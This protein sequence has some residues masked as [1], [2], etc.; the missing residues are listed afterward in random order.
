MK[1]LL[2]IWL[3]GICVV[4]AIIL[5]GTGANYLVEFL[6]NSSASIMGGFVVIALLL[7]SLAV[8]LFVKKW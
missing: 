3:T 5:A 6:W 2:S 1:K 8:G 7:I 4:S